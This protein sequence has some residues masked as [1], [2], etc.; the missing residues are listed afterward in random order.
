MSCSSY[1]LEVGYVQFGIADSLGIYSACFRIYSTLYGIW[2]A[3]LD[4]I[5]L[6][7]QF[8]KG[9]VQQLVGAAIEIIG[10]YDLLSC[11]VILRSASV[12]AAWPEATASAP[13]PPSIAAMRRSNTSVVGFMIRE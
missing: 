11:L 12:A 13:V 9:I 1:G 7:A 10:R 5:N 2:I 8:G 6:P 4:K 3:R